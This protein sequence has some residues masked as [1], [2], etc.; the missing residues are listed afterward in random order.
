VAPSRSATA[1]PPLPT[2]PD[3]TSWPPDYDVSVVGAL[4]TVTR[5]RLPYEGFRYEFYDATVDQGAQKVLLGIMSGQLYKAYCDMQTSY[6]Q[7]TIAQRRYECVPPHEGS[8]SGPGDSC[9]VYTTA[10]PSVGIGGECTAPGCTRVGC[11]QL[12][13]CEN[14]PG[15]DCDNVGCT[16][17]YVP[18]S[19][20]DLQLDG[21]TAT[22]QV[23]LDDGIHALHLT[24]GQ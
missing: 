18:D 11:Q 20:F 13:L 3:E 23:S 6:L 16:V 17:N 10:T 19:T 9:A 7:S 12:L 15:C 14:D 5:S 22:G 4:G 24:R 8:G 2:G 21:D 1:P